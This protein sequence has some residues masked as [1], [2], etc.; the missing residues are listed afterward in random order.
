MN[1]FK[2]ENIKERP[3]RLIAYFIYSIIIEQTRN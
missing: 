1:L 2:I 3:L